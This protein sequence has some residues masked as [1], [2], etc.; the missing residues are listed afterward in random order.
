M[1]RSPR[2]PRN[3]KSFRQPIPGQTHKNVTICGHLIDFKRDLVCTLFPRHTARTHA[4]IG[5]DADGILYL[6]YLREG[7]EV[8]EICRV[9]IDPTAG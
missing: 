1:T 5:N 7:E 9:D 3:R 2:R 8:S 4:C 6:V